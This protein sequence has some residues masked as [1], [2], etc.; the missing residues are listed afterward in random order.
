[1]LCGIECTE[2]VSLQAHKTRAYREYQAHDF[3][4]RIY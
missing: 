1:M 4:S 3:Y 2:H